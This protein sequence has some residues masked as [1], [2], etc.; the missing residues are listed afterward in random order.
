MSAELISQ[1]EAESATAGPALAE[2]ALAA[3]VRMIR[4]VAGTL[5]D[6]TA[7]FAPVGEVVLDGGRVACHLCGRLFK[8]VTAHLPAHGWTKDEYCAAFGLER[9]QSLEGPETRKLRSAAFSAR[10]I[11]EPAVRAGSAAGRARAKAGDLARDAATA[12]RGRPFPEQRRR[13]ASRAGSA[14]SSAAAARAGRERSDRQLAA[15][16]AEVARQHGYPAIGDFVL[17]RAQEGLSLAA[18]SREAGLHKDWLSRHLPRLDPAAARAAVQS[19]EVRPDLSWLPVVRQLGFEDVAGYLRD[20]HV[21]K[22]LSVNAIA[23]ETG[24]SHHAVRTALDR[25]GLT[26]VPHAQRRHAAG[27]RAAEVAARFGHPTIASY[28]AQRRA[29]GWTWNAIAAESA[30]PQTWL[31]RHAPTPPQA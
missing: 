25:H 14:A 19:R 15:V 4:P 11:F 21:S 23:A 26:P 16:A 28:I 7:F 2:A 17:A 24:V 12:A 22:H 27:Q 8:S 30:Q 31:R 6:G 3:P 5:A 9:S 29:A 1:V 18:I 10:L 20:R 13:K